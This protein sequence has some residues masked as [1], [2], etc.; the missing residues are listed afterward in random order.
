MPYQTYFR[1]VATA[2]VFVLVIALVATM[3]AVSADG[4]DDVVISVQKSQQQYPNLG[5]QL[6][7]M[8]SNVQ[9]GRMSASDAAGGAAISSNESVAVTI[10]LWGLV[11]EVVAFLEEFGGDPRNVGEDYIEAYVPLSLLGPVSERPGVLRVRQIIPPQPA[12]LSQQVIG[13]GPDLHGSP[14][15]NAA[16]FSGQG[17]KVG[18]IDLSFRGVTT[19]LGTEL[20]AT[21]VARCYSDVGMFTNNLDDCEPSGEPPDPPRGCPPET[22]S[23]G[24]HGT[25]VAESL[26]DMA[27]GVTLYV[28]DPYSRGDLL[29]T[30]EW[31]GSEGVQVINYSV[32][33]I[34]DG[35]GDGTSPYSDSPLNTVDRA[36]EEDILW[37]SSA[38]NAA[39]GTWFGGYSDSD[40]DKFLDFGGSIE[41]VIDLPVYEC[42]RHVVQLRWEDS[43]TAA[44]TDMD[45]HLYNKVTNEIVFSSDDPQSGAAGHEPWEAFA[46]TLPFRSNTYGIKVTHYSGE[47]PDWIQVTVWPPV[48]PIEPHTLN[49]SITNPAESAN[50]G[51]LAVGAA[52]WYNVD[53]IEYFSSRGPTPDGRTK[54]DIVG[55]D[56]GETALRTYRPDTNRGFCGTSQAAPHVSGM[57]ALVRQR[58]PDL[59]AQQTASYMKLRAEGRGTVPNNT[60]GYG[61]AQLPAAD[62]LPDA[63]LPEIPQTLVACGATVTSDGTIRGTWE[64]ECQ[65][66]VAERGYAKYYSFTLDEEREVTIDL[67]SDG[68][69][70]LYLRE[71]SARNWSSLHENDDIERGGVNLNSHISETLPAGTYT[72]EATT[73]DE[74]QTGSF[75]LTISGLLGTTTDPDPDPDPDACAVTA[76]TADDSPVTGAWIT[77]CQSQVPDRGYARYYSFT[78]DQQSQVTIDLQSTV[79]PFLY[80]RRGTATSGAALHENDDVDQPGGN[81]NSQ[82]SQTLA[83]ATYTIEAATFDDD[84]TGAFTL[85]ISGLSGDGGV[86]EPETDACL[87]T[88]AVDGT[89]NGTW[90]AGCDSE[91]LAPG[92][93]SGARLARYY[94]FTL[95][96]PSDVTIDLVSDLDTFLYLRTGNARTG[97]IL[98]ENDDV[99]RPAGDYDSQISETLMAGTYTIE[100]TTYNA[101]QAGTFTLTISG[102]GI[103]PPTMTS[104][105]L[106]LVALFNATDGPN[107]RDG[108][109]WLTDAPIGEWYGVTTDG[110]GRVTF[111]TLADNQLAGEIPSELGRLVNLEELDLAD[112]RLTGTI[113]LELG[114]LVNLE[115]LDLSDNQLTG[116]IPLELGSLVNLEGLDLSGNQLTGTIPLELGSLSDLIELT[117]ADNRL[118][119]TVP[120]ELGSLVNLQILT[121]ASNRLTGTI[122]LELGNLG[123]LQILTLASNQLTGTIPLELGSLSDLIELTLASN[124][125]TGTIPLELGSLA[126]L[127]KVSLA[128]NLLTGCIPEGLRDVP[129][130]DFTPLGL[131]FCGPDTS[132]NSF[133]LAATG[134][135][136]VVTLNWADQAGIDTWQVR[137]RAEG[138]FYGA[139]TNVSGTDPQA[140]ITPLVNAVRYCFQ[141]R[142]LQGNTAGPQSKEACA[143]TAA[144]PEQADD[145]TATAGIRQVTLTWDNP[146]DD[147]IT[148]WQ[149]RYTTTGSFTVADLWKDIRNS[150]ANTVSH[151]VENLDSG[152]QYTFQVRALA[153]DTPGLAADPESTGSDVVTLQPGPPVG[154][155]AE[156]GDGQV[157][158]SWSDPGDDGIYKWQYQ[159]RVG[160]GEFGDW[161]DVFVAG[162]GPNPTDDA[163]RAATAAATTVV[164]PSLASGVE[165]SFQVRAVA[166]ADPD[167][168]T[169]NVAA[170]TVTAPPDSP[171]VPGP[172]ASAVHFLEAPTAAAAVAGGIPDQAIALGETRVLDLS[173]FFVDGRGA[174]AIDGY[175]ADVFP[176]DGPLFAQ[177]S[178]GSLLTMIG[179]S[180]G[181]A[182]VGATAID[183]YDSSGSGDAADDDPSLNFV[184]TV[185]GSS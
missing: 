97:A 151:T 19:L 143:I 44:R 69:P 181:V 16:G 120:L 15:W 148:E 31:M 157:I 108:A 25:I 149:Y 94:S 106:A 117:L 20:P 38:G 46:F 124:Q 84:E 51:L 147:T 54:P 107:W 50:P 27:P 13:D 139:W 130:N 174:G 32:G 167:A 86:G 180:E 5:S 179:L 133:P 137:W 112:N 127:R 68:D 55:A 170:R 61:F 183:G 135:A 104:D 95:D 156:A 99:D 172:A 145:L 29:E 10:Y 11:D 87:E 88:L 122:P 41:E 114:S 118:T 159:Y 78:L 49:G 126:N 76:I 24:G 176:G 90:S 109:G 111:L 132:G 65:S 1:S 80:L 98:H 115:G 36:V 23:P 155:A 175:R 85:T 123:N 21:I 141:V 81:Y 102:L 33:Y 161:T 9:E 71:G 26:L 62:A 182:V 73:Y 178:S 8:V 30:V 163:T 154:L 101:D 58:F 74:E 169:V 45:L 18:V 134:G 93:G 100:A 152:K 138:E 131:P 77:D 28:A 128:G 70:Y 184:V 17:V 160:A 158:L 39:D 60:W 79:D 165:Y 66:Y 113:P 75:T 63:D 3:S 105:R 52:P 110:V 82:I 144:A 34:F 72:I 136:G 177:I 103:A 91:T 64:E 48:F 125:L 171:D 59:T 119:G 129:D 83:A 92:S 166:T 67:E 173:V 162:A 6:N 89:T 116:T 42:L 43:W 168:V 96:Q 153:H 56:C 7:Q 140:T 142:A 53:T 146:T 185:S 121:L 14:A 22:P 37:V 4:D 150:N 164:V 57:A 12:Q 35:P 2:A 40:G 47:M